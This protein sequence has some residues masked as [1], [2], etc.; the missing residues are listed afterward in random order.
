MKM[1]NLILYVSL[2]VVTA[3]LSSRIQAQTKFYSDKKASYIEYAMKHPLH[4]WTGKS[5]DFTSVIV[6]DETKTKISQV[7]VSVKISSFDS[8]N[9]NRDSHTIEATDAIKYPSITFASSSITQAGDKLTVT[10]ALTFHGVTHTITFEA[11]EK[12]V[13]SSVEVSGAFSVNMTDY[14]I[15]R[16]SLMGFPTEDEIKLDFKAIY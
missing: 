9:A 3:T 11:T 12:K 13:G 2:M 5:S 15:E 16:P 8:K 6:A 10:G 4:S 14:K 7:A 1:K